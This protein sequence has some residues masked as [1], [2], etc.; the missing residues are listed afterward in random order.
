MNSYSGSLSIW[1]VICDFNTSS[2]WCFGFNV[3]SVLSVLLP[4]W[5]TLSVNVDWTWLHLDSYQMIWAYFKII[6]KW[7]IWY[8]LLY[9]SSSHCFFV[10]EFLVNLI[11]PFSFK[12][13]CVLN[14]LLL[15][16]CLHHADQQ[17]DKNI[18]FKT[19]CDNLL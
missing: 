1:Q 4:C 3:Q 10:C 14:F 18:Y 2:F 5:R 9:C 17:T 12:I 16:T 7:E 13:C 8:S 19:L 15:V 6:Y 11:Y